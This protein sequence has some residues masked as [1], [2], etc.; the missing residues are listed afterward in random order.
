MRKNICF[1]SILTSSLL[2]VCTSLLAGPF[3]YSKSCKGGFAAESKKVKKAL[4]KDHSYG[5]VH[6]VPRLDPLLNEAE[7]NF[8][9]LQSILKKVAYNFEG[10]FGE[11]NINTKS[12]L[13][14]IDKQARKKSQGK[15]T[16]HIFDFLRGTIVFED[17]NQLYA[18]FG[19]F[20]KFYEIAKVKD[21]FRNPK[22]SG[23]RSI[24]FNMKIPSTGYIVEVQL[25]IKE[26]YELKT[27]DK[28]LDRIYVQIRDLQLQ[29]DRLSDNF[30][31]SIELQK[32]KSQFEKT[33]KLYLDEKNNE[34]NTVWFRDRV[35]RV[36][37]FRRFLKRELK[38]LNRN[39]LR[40][41]A[42]AVDRELKPLTVLHRKLYDEAWDSFSRRKI[43]ELVRSVNV[44]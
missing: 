23:Y 44:D 5:W 6:R 20:A 9:L 42:I 2:L 33:V 1:Y 24:Q 35:I 21:Y 7:T 12:R 22:E 36:E 31:K 13:S 37:A 26:L 14:S 30:Q 19:H 41:Q 15:K 16:Q 3:N 18:S 25:Q 27:K 38:K 29:K 17:I 8:P 43:S 11:R 40:E 39:E 28:G 4:E 10:S 32:T 34:P